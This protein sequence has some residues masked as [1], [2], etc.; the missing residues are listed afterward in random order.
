MRTVP[1]GS[2]AHTSPLVFCR[3][4]ESAGEHDRLARANGERG[5]IHLQL[6]QLGLGG[7][8]ERV[9]RRVVEQC[10]RSIDQGGAG[11]RY[12]LRREIGGRRRSV[13]P[14]QEEEHV[15]GVDHVQFGGAGGGG[16]TR[17]SV[18]DREC[19]RAGHCARQLE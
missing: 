16:Q 18:D 9:R 3:L 13:H 19:A 2:P 6:D 5:R 4:T 10:R 11:H 8:I 1:R 12:N 7:R 14:E 17:I 15:V